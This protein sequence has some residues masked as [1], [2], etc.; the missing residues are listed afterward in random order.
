M[1][2]KY[3]NAI[4]DATIKMNFERFVMG[5]VPASKPEEWIQPV[6]CDSR[7][8]GEDWGSFLTVGFD[9]DAESTL[10]VF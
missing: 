7:V 9:G 8:H 10:V 5:Y 3:S 6:K 2:N 1:I 4:E